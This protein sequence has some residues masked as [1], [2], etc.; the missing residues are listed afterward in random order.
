M[1]SVPD[2]SAPNCDSSDEDD[3]DYC[4]GPDSDEGESGCDEPSSPSSFTADF[5]FLSDMGIAV[6]APNASRIGKRTR[7]NWSL[8]TVDVDLLKDRLDVPLTGK[9]EDEEDCIYRQFLHRVQTGRVDK[10]D[11]DDADEDYSIFRDVSIYEDDDDYDEEYTNDP[12]MIVPADEVASLQTDLVQVSTL[13]PLPQTSS[14]MAALQPATPTADTPFSRDLWSKVKL[15]LAWH[16]QLLVQQYLLC[17]KEAYESCLVDQDAVGNPVFPAPVMKCYSLLVEIRKCR[18][19]S[20]VRYWNPAPQ[21]QNFAMDSFLKGGSI[22]DVGALNF[23]DLLFRETMNDSA[24][25]VEDI[26]PL[27]EMFEAYF[28]VGLYPAFPDYENECLGS[29]MFIQDRMLALGA[30]RHYDLRKKTILWEN[31]QEEFLPSRTATQLR[32]RWNN[33]VTPRAPPGILKLVRA[34]IQR[35]AKDFVEAEKGGKRRKKRR[36]TFPSQSPAS[37]E[38]HVP[39]QEPVPA[40]K[41]HFLPL[42][43]HGRQWSLHNVSPRVGSTQTRFSPTQGQGVGAD[44]AYSGVV[45]H[46]E[47]LTDSEPEDE[48]DMYDPPSPHFSPDPPASG[49]VSGDAGATGGRSGS[50]HDIGGP[51]TPISGSGNGLAGAELNFVMPA[52]SAIEFEREDLCTSESETEGEKLGEFAHQESGLVEHARG[53]AGGTELRSRGRRSTKTTL[54]TPAPTPPNVSSGYSGNA[55]SSAP[56]ATH[57]PVNSMA[58]PTKPASRVPEANQERISGPNAIPANSL[59]ID[60]PADVSALATEDIRPPRPPRTT[61]VDPAP[62]ALPLQEGRGSAG[63]PVR[64]DFADSRASVL[65]IPSPGAPSVQSPPP[66]GPAQGDHP[67]CDSSGE[68]AANGVDAH[69]PSLGTGASRTARLDSTAPPIRTVHWAGGEGKEPSRPPLPPRLSDLAS[70]LLET[71]ESV[72]SGVV[73]V[74]SPPIVTTNTDTPATHMRVVD[75][76]HLNEPDSQF[77]R[78]STTSAN[79]ALNGNSPAG[80]RL[81]PAV[82]SAAPATPTKSKS[83]VEGTVPTSPQWTKEEDKKLLLA[84]KTSKGHSIESTCAALVRAGQLKPGRTVE[85]AEQRFHYL[86]SVFTSKKRKSL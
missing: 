14:Q 77:V 32:N 21:P 73:S 38:A 78:N 69:A 9:E 70:G 6:P 80:S 26:R 34:K 45:F 67:H 39:M 48:F 46:R 30:E 18:D 55:K 64:L 43:G 72:S 35:R 42:G 76:N 65:T 27:L 54:S 71:S 68:C 61:A 53:G 81:V 22:F 29:R 7:A 3:E 86:V 36:L 49:T 8:K 28:F 17:R 82:P 59:S 79:A 19:E 16:V 15:Q 31:V 12:T 52:T 50:S 57:K 63:D 58:I 37:T 41:P 33:R 5:G 20:P 51:W 83:Q 47:E 66:P 60:V 1:I 75:S 84:W 4:P 62:Q 85:E 2:R 10:D 24:K 56:D 44:A 11:D 23:L 13:T 74:P 25:F 40:A